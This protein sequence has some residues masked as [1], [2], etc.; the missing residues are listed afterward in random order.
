MSIGIIKGKFKYLSNYGYRRLK[1]GKMYVA[2]EF[3]NVL[4][5]I[6]C[7]AENMI[8]NVGM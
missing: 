1:L 5:R 2:K 8:L 7:G 4:M 3:N 6:E